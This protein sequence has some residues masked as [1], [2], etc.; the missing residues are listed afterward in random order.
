MGL[1]NQAET[2]TVRLW[3][4]DP[5]QKVLEPLSWFELGHAPPHGC[6][7]VHFHSAAYGNHA[8]RP[9][10]VALNADVGGHPPSVTGSR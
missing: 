3:R 8:T 10:C 5:G 2:V 1:R 4:G 9:V 6:Q 7:S